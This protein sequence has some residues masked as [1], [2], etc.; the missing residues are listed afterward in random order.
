MRTWMNG[1]RRAALAGVVLA[2]VAIG[3]GMLLSGGC[4]SAI[5]VD[6]QSVIGQRFP[7]VRGEGLDGK[8]WTLPEDLKG[9][10]AVLFVGYK[11]FTQFDIDRWMIALDMLSTPVAIYEIPTIAGMVP[12]MFANQIDDGM[13]KGIPRELWSAVITVYSDAKAIEQFTGTENPMPSR[14]LLLDAEGRVVWFH[15]RGFGPQFAK[16]LDAAV[17]R[18]PAG[19]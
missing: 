19:G 2:G 10:P 12:G 8:K 4:A 15:D 6:P 3:G 18:L 11:Q 5:K 1:W 16:E 14:V 17:R 7:T 9:K 13:R